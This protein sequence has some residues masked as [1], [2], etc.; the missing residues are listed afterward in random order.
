[1]R[2]SKPASPPCMGVGWQTWVQANHERPAAAENA[3]SGKFIG[4]PVGADA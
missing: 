1:M 4:L 3:A 2:A